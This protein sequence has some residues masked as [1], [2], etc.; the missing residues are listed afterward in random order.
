MILNQGKLRRIQLI[1]F[2]IDDEGPLY[3]VP[4]LVNDARAKATL[5]RLQKLSTPY[6]T[7]IT[8]KGWYG[9]IEL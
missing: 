9:E 2:A 6:G 1:P 4:R 3:G 7:K 8:P 5:E